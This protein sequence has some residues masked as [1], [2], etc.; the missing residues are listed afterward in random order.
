MADAAIAK[1]KSYI[2]DISI[3]W[4][5]EAN[6]F[7]IASEYETSL[8]KVRDLTQEQIKNA[9]NAISRL[10]SIIDYQFVALTLSSSI[11]AETIV[12]NEKNGTASCQ[13][14]FRIAMCSFLP[15]FILILRSWMALAC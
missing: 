15:T 3:L 8:A 2:T 14:R 1:D 9:Q 5:P 4:K 11:S 6:I 7:Q 10:R 12:P 13:S